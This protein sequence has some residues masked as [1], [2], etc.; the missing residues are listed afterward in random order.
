[1]LHATA[2]RSLLLM[3]LLGGIL[4][5]CRPKNT[6]DDEATAPTD[7]AIID[8]PANGAINSAASVLLKNYCRHF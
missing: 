4:T 1:M 8:D 3:V 6:T 2:L 5:G 7:S